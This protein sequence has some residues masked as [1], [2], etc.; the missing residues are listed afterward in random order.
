M[1][2]AEA[3]T[4]TSGLDHFRAFRTRTRDRQA[5]QDTAHPR[6][7]VL[8][9]LAIGAL[10]AV[11]AA[12]IASIFV[13]QRPA[14]VSWSHELV[15]V[16]VPA[17]AAALC[18]RTALRIDHS[19]AMWWLFALGAALW[20]GGDLGYTVMDRLGIDPQALLTWADGLYLAL[21]P[22]WAAALVIHPA[23]GHRR[24]EQVGTGLDAAAVIV[25]IGAVAW[26]YILGPL[27]RDAENFA[28]AVTAVSYPVG[29]LALLTAFVALVARAGGRLRRC[30]GFMGAGIVAFAF[31]DLVYARLALSGSYVTGSA[32]D[33]LFEAGFAGVGIAAV[34]A[35]RSRT[36]ETADPRPGALTGVASLALLAGI[37]SIGLIGDQKMVL[38]AGIVMGL[39]IASRQT[40]LLWD[41]RRLLGELEL[42]TTAAE[43]ANL[44][45]T[46]FL[47]HMSHE[48][49]TPLTSILGYADLLEIASPDDMTMY[50]H[51]I[52]KSGEHLHD[53]VRD[54]L[55]ISRIEQGRLGFSMEPLGLDSLVEECIDIVGPNAQASSVS[56]VVDSDVDKEASVFADRQR[57][58][59]VLLNLLSNG[60]KYNREEGTLSVRWD[61]ADRGRIRLTVSD[62]GV[63]IPPEALDRLFTPFERLGS[64]RGTKGTG[65]GLALAKRM[66]EAMRGDIGV[67]SSVGRGTTFWIELPTATLPTLPATSA[68]KATARVRL[69][70]TVLY[71][72]DNIS[73]VQL[74]ED[75]LAS[76]DVKLV[77]TVEG[78]KGVQMAKDDRPD[79][80]LLDRH[81]PDA[82][83]ED[84]L[85][86]LKRS[87]RTA[88]IPVVIL[89]A[90]A[91][92]EHSE[93][94]LQSGA[95]AY[96]TK[97]IDIERFIGLLAK[98]L[99]DRG[100]A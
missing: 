49:G 38:G 20:A 12:Y 36:W 97:P 86:E 58:K 7:S 16:I 29:D 40:L 4:L 35:A 96:L 44:A 11:T 79:V 14:I 62:T 39:L 80:I 25:G 71:I 31:A 43:S 2:L 92:I 69:S 53:I 87:A 55:D 21:I 83:A 85:I 24:F 88:D 94:L 82:S 67:A 76:Q 95:H 64:A 46:Q 60:V 74:V 50:A 23:R 28:G 45:K 75:M 52:R 61:R 3:R 41:R 78:R 1:A 84:V 59:Q 34:C 48:I 98:L 81:L 77:S 37:S 51:R 15:P 9:Q 68:D 18:I 42:A 70:G 57:L 26:V 10:G 32:V 6:A 13:S 100:A 17:I 22:L 72:E 93:S 65:L 89:S 56:I 30:D 66:I 63:G 19:R 27:V 33:L 5:A 47:S 8:R 73:N 90:D 54:A 91:S 99:N